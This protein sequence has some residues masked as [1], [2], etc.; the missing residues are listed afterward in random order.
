MGQFPSIDG[1]KSLDSIKSSSTSTS[2]SPESVDS[3][4]P[5]PR[6]AEPS[7]PPPDTIDNASTDDNYASL[8]YKTLKQSEISSDLEE[9]RKKSLV[10]HQLKDNGLLTDI[11]KQEMKQ[12]DENI[13]YQE[14]KLKRLQTDANRQQTR[15]RELKRK[16]AIAAESNQE[17]AKFNRG[18]TGRPSTDVCQPG[19]LAVIQQIA[20]TGA[21]AHNRRRSEQLKSIKTLNDFHEA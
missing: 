17:L 20:A 21:A 12:V 16:I 8:K 18:A 7:H 11:H 19:L 1:Q 3:E 5:S 2:I 4:V 10:L 15:R 6:T 9:L 13:K 14:L